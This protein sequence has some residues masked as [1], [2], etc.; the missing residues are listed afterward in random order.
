MS[1]KP[2][3]IRP[4]RP[5]DE[6][7]CVAL[8][9]ELAVFEKKDAGFRITPEKLAAALSSVQPSI[10]GLLAETPEGE[11]VG[12]AFYYWSLGT[13]SG[14]PILHIEDLYTV[15]SVRGQGLGLALFEAL[16]DLANA[17]QAL[18][19]QWHVL[20][21]NTDAIGFYE[22]RLGATLDTEWARYSVPLLF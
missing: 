4:L 11:A 1:S 12:Y 9:R 10:H 19:M 8:L 5:G 6:T 13:F 14:Q 15:P 18:E 7:I 3:L 17:R 2:Y 22:Q 21:W 20:H 16:R